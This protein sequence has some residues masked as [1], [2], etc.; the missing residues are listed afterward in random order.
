LGRGGWRA[1]EVDVVKR[2]GG[3]ADCT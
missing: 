1:A 3:T 2:R